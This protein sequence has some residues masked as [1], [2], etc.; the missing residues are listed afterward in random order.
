MTTKKYISLI[1]SVLV[2]YILQAAPGTYYNSIDTNISCANF[3]TVLA[4]LLT[5]NSTVLPY[6]IVD[7]NFNKTDLKPATGLSYRVSCF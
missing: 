5:S 1:L 6:G 7:D 3:K 2:T 4:R